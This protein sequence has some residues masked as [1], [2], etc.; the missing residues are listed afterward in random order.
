[1]FDLNGKTSSA[2]AIERNVVGQDPLK[3]RLLLFRW[4]IPS[5]LN[6]L[7][8]FAAQLGPNTPAIAVISIVNGDRKQT[9]YKVVR[10]VE[11]TK[12]SLGF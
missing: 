7:V 2:S 6:T 11:N 1:M 10:L 3:W 12:I 4:R 5:M 9:T 8:R